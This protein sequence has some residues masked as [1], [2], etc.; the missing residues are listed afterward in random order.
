MANYILYFTVSFSKQ[1]SFIEQVKE[2]LFKLLHGLVV[3]QI[4]LINAIYGSSIYFVCNV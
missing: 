3:N 1:R 2:K 4:M